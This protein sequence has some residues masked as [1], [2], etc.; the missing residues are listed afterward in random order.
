M[1]RSIATQEMLREAGLKRPVFRPFQEVVDVMKQDP[2]ATKKKLT[3]LVKAKVQATD[4]AA[5]L[6]HSVVLEVQL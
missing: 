4:N 2:G 5:R 6:A 3:T 1:V